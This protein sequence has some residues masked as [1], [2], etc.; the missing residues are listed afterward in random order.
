[1]TRSRS[2]LRAVLVLG[3]ISFA[4]SV[5]AAPTLTPHL[6]EVQA[7]QSSDP[8]ISEP[9]ARVDTMLQTHDFDKA[10]ERPKKHIDSILASYNLHGEEVTENLSALKSSLAALPPKPPAIIVQRYQ[11]LA[12]TYRSILGDIEGLMELNGSKNIYR[13]AWVSTERAL[14]HSEE[15]AR[16]FR[17]LEAHL[18]AGSVGR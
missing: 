16:V 17:D 3:V 10:H 8:P 14:Q 6:T 18:T 15:R 2:V 5:F 13:E 12:D 11:R 4:S 1:M 7:H 9:S